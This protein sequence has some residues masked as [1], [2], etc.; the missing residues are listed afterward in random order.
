MHRRR[1]YKGE[2]RRRIARSLAKGLSRSAA[3]GHPKAGETAALKGHSAISP[4]DPLHK[5]FERVKAGEGLAYTAKALRISRERLR[6][7]VG[8]VGEFRRHEGRWRI[9]ADHRRFQLPMY[10]AGRT[11]TVTV[12]AEGAKELGRFMAAVARFLA[13]NRAGILKP[14]EGRGLV[15][16]FGQFIPF[17]TDANALYALDAKGELTFHQIYQITL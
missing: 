5:G 10:S 12:D 1:D 8:D 6:Q 16:I 9:V 17:E 13:T 11:R 2:Y 3:R 15:N 14:Y 7:Y 4:D